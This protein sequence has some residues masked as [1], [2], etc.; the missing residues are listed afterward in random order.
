M[1]TGLGS[2][3]AH[4]R[5]VVPPGHRKE[6]KRFLKFGTIGFSGAA[7]DFGL[8]NF[9]FFVLGWPKFWAN[10][11]SF[12]LSV[13]NNF[14]WNRLWTFPESRERAVHGQLA[15]FMMVYFVGWTINQTVFL[16]SDH[17]IYS[18]YF[19]TVWSLNFAKVTASFVAMFWNFGA[20]RLWTYRG[21]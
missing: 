8:L 7:V 16:G 3:L 14:T 20:N 1:I 21:L 15:Q 4:Y 5:E 9:F 2:L 19:A 12:S 10:T 13:L 18:H 6:I 11:A 17:F